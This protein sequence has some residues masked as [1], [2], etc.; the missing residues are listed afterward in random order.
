MMDRAERIKA[1]ETC[2]FDLFRDIDLGRHE[3]LDKYFTDSADFRYAMSRDDAE[4]GDYQ[5]VVGSN[6][7]ATLLRATFS[8]LAATHHSITNVS[9]EF[10][11]PLGTDGTVR[12]TGHMRAYHKGAGP[13]AHLFEESLSIFN[14]EFRAVEGRMRISGFSYVVI[15]VLGSVEVFT[16]LRDA[17]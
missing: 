10:A 12:S 4:R 1:A 2:L 5:G 3:D 13:M 7:I 9:T 8:S 11:D 15:V 6:D 14:V 17:S 16:G